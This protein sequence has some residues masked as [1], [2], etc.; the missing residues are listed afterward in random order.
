MHEAHDNLVR[1]SVKKDGLEKAIRA[2]QDMDIKQ[3][4]DISHKN[5]GMHE[6]IHYIKLHQTFQY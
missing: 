2:R 6:L 4:E 3:L 5:K 1:S